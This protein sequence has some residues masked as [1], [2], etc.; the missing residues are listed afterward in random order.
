MGDP[1]GED[2]RLADA[3]AGENEDRP[4]Q[5]LD[6]APLLFVQSIEIGG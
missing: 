6:R 3:G 2:A 5:R 4:V 1:G